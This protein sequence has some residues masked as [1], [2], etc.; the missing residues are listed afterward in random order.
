MIYIIFDCVDV[1]SSKCCFCTSKLPTSHFLLSFT[2]LYLH[3]L[4]SPSP[5]PL[6]HVSVL[7]YVF[8]VC[9]NSRPS[10]LSNPSPVTMA[11]ALPSS[12]SA[13]S[14]LLPSPWRRCWSARKSSVPRSSSPPLGF[15][16][17]APRSPTSSYRILCARVGWNQSSVFAL[18]RRSG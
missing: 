1:C 12:S 18:V 16:A 15:K 17:S 10:P 9:R 2:T 3:I 4:P 13:P 14:L 5:L 7:S 11:S 8:Q 6:H